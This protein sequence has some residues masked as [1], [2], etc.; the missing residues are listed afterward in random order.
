RERRR[1]GRATRG[2][3]LRGRRPTDG[4]RPD[5][6]PC[7]AARKHLGAAASLIETQAPGYVLRAGPDNLDALRFERMV[8]GGSLA[9]AQGRADEAS[10]TLGL[11]RG[12][13]LADFVYESFA[14]SAITKL[15]ELQLTALERGI[16]ADLQLGRNATLVAEL[17]ALVAEHPLREQFRAQLMLALRASSRAACSARTRRW[18][19]PSRQRIF[20]TRTRASAR[21][22]R[23]TRATSSA[24]RSSCVRSSSAFGRSASSPPSARAGAG[25]RP[26]CWP[27]SSRRCAPVR[28]LG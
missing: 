14:Q 13:A 21:S 5:P 4:D 16:E 27:A 20:A 17:E 7:L 19:S 12:P 6:R 1:A 9:L 23:A 11:W 3:A 22:A 2:G 24:A 25:S 10:R 28:S 26:R 15:E 18:P 8:E